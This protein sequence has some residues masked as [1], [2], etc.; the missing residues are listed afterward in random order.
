MKRY[1][2]IVFPTL[3]VLSVSSQAETLELRLVS[4]TGESEVLV[5]TNGAVVSMEIQGRLVS[6]DTDGLGMWSA[7][8]DRT[9]VLEFDYSTTSGFDALAPATSERFDLVQCEIAVSTAGVNTAGWTTLATGS[10]EVSGDLGD[11]AVLTLNDAYATTVEDLGGGDY[12]ASAADVSIVGGPLTVRMV[13]MLTAADSIGYVDSN[14]TWAGGDI[15]Y[16]IEINTAV[17][18]SG[19]S[20]SRSFSHNGDDLWVRMT[21]EDDVNASSISFSITPDAGTNATL[22]QGPANNIVGFTWDG[23]PLIDLTTT[24]SGPQYAYRIELDGAAGGEFEIAYILGDVNCDGIDTGYDV[25]TIVDGSNWIKTVDDASDPRADVDRNGIVNYGDRYTVQSEGQWLK[26]D[27]MQSGHVAVKCPAIGEIGDPDNC[28]E[29][30]VNYVVL[31]GGGFPGV[32]DVTFNADVAP[33]GTYDESYWRVWEGATPHDPYS[34][35]L[36]SQG[37][38]RI[39]VF[40]VGVY[41]TEV[42]YLGGDSS[43]TVGSDPMCPFREPVP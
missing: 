3:L 35:S 20:E 39:A 14:G 6:G 11:T 9:G 7:N 41:I 29:S 12:D 38:V 19:L 26:P 34:V 16:P 42:E 31:A 23:P 22:T 18:T 10:A 21:F 15:E 32:I 2:A 36:Y 27:P 8:V 25:G 37:R 17:G 24:G 4:D 40:V 13:S 5:N 30:Q 1:L 28:D 43:L 33:T